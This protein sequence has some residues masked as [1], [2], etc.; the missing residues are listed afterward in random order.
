LSFVS[1]GAPETHAYDLLA[2]IVQQQMGGA[3]SALQALASTPSSENTDTGTGTG[4][5]GDVIDVQV[6]DVSN[7][8]PTAT[9]ATRG[10]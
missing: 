4:N 8:S 6:V 5:K 2:A 3:L 9:T 1:N 10:F 7:D